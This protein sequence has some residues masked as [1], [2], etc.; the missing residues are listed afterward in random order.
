MIASIGY[1]R[2]PKD[3]G[4]I[5]EIDIYPQG[6]NANG[7]RNAEVAFVLHYGT[8]R[9]PGSHWVDDADTLAGPM[10]STAM[11]SIFDTFM[12]TGEVPKVDVPNWTAERNS[13][14]AVAQERRRTRR[15]RKK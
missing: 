4:G 11:T 6:V 3:V 13:A 8:S 7:V 2:R 10:I 12:A 14:K 5:R 15:R 9:R 1:P